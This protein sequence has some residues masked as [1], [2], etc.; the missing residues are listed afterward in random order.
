MKF[1]ASISHCDDCRGHIVKSIT[2]GNNDIATSH[3][4]ICNGKRREGKKCENAKE[5]SDLWCV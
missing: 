5:H 2:D 3:K 4:V 1:L